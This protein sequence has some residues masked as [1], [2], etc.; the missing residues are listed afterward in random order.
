[1]NRD[2]YF[3]MYQ[4]I[5]YIF[6]FRALFPCGDDMVCIIDDREDVWSH[7][8]NLIHVKPY[9]FFQHT[10]DINAPPGLDKHED[11]DK[12]GVDLTKFV[13]KTSEKSDIDKTED[14]K[15]NVEQTEK[16]DEQISEKPKKD[17]KEEDAPELDS[18]SNDD[19]DEQI[20]ENSKDDSK[21]ASKLNN[22]NK[23]DEQKSENSKEDVQ[24]KKP[25]ELNENKEVEG[26][27][28]KDNDKK[29]N[30][31]DVDNPKDNLKEP[32]NDSTEDQK[33]DSNSK[34]ENNELNTKTANENNGKLKVVPNFPVTENKT[35]D[36]LIEIEDQDDYIVYLEDIL[37][38]IHKEYYELYD[39]MESG[40]LPD[41][42]N[43]IPCK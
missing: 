34:K 24:E 11:D 4:S 30:K 32:D 31:T 23:D 27:I 6:S 9:H 8:S 35:E 41:L 20:N 15:E 3:K 37:K 33:E 21:K 1:M 43:V 29:S 36:N 42:K 40:K 19:D 10:G 22:E 16:N 7:A 38:R 2:F 28:Q 12:E 17:L 39:K 14:S 18:K 5:L 26:E 25:S 13:K